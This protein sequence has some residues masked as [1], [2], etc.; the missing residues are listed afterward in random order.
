MLSK[1]LLS[2]LSPPLSRRLSL[3]SSHFISIDHLFLIRQIKLVFC[4]S[5]QQY[6][7]LPILTFPSLARVFSTLHSIAA[8]F[9]SAHIP[10]HGFPTFS[11]FSLS[12][13]PILSRS[14]SPPYVV[15]QVT[16]MVLW[17]GPIILSCSLMQTG[18]GNLSIKCH[19][20]SLLFPTCSVLTQIWL[21]YS[22][23]ESIT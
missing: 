22:T 3:S 6:F 4:F 11:P 15:D 10:P 8:L 7:L 12:R 21:C 23:V 13:H 2:A 9:L 16:V 19:F 14:R 17:P 18:N 5:F 20:K 1:L